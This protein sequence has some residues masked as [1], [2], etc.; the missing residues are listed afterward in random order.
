[1]SNKNK[2]QRRRDKKLQ[3]QQRL[4]DLH[5]RSDSR[6]KKLLNNAN[7]ELNN[8]VGVLIDKLINTGL[9]DID[10][11]IQLTTMLS[12]HNMQS[13]VIINNVQK[14][15]DVLEPVEAIGFDRGAWGQDKK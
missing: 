5:N 1:M 6:Y 12:T 8:A 11:R 9:S 7:I 3:R 13:S 14:A 10:A 15:I 4:D 2:D